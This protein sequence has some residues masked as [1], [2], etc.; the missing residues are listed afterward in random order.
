MKDYTTFMVNGKANLT[1]NKKRSICDELREDYKINLN[2]RNF[3]LTEL[4]SLLE[5]AKNK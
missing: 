4:R 2:Y 3:S 1:N 5:E